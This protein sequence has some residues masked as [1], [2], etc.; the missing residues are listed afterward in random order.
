MALIHLPFKSDAPWCSL[1]STHASKPHLDLLPPN[2]RSV[3]FPSATQP[4]RFTM[5]KPVKGRNEPIAVG[6]VAWVIYSLHRN[7]HEEA[8]A[9]GQQM[10]EIPF[11]KIVQKAY[12]NTVSLFR[13]DELADA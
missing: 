9:N 4:E 8:L 2:Y 3:F 10:E 11:W 13:L 1:T 6:G 12:K 5:G 7:A